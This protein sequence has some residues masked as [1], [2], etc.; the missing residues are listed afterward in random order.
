MLDTLKKRF[1][2]HST[3]IGL[4]V[5]LAS[6]LKLFF[7]E[8]G[9]IIDGLIALAGGTAIALPDKKQVGS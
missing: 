9:I 3:K 8:Y 2:E 4:I 7:P 5:V 6:A 1:G